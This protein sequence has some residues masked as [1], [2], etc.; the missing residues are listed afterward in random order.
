[1]RFEA[2]GGNACNISTIWFP[3][4]LAES[5][6]ELIIVDVFVV[7]TIPAAIS[8]FGPLRCPAGK[9]LIAVICVCWVALTL[10]E[11]VAQSLQDKDRSSSVDCVTAT[12]GVST[13]F[14][15]TSVDELRQRLQQSIVKIGAVRH[16]YAACCMLAQNSLRS[17]SLS[18]GGA[19]ADK[20]SLLTLGISLRL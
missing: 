7:R 12:F 9:F 6:S 13:P 14:A 3:F 17:F 5:T 18:S 11:P 15:N 16:D 20:P 19:L 10:V 8:M 2:N 4:P 1:M